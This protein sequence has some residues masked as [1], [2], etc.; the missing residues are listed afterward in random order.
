MS[1]VTVN[2]F[3]VQLIGFIALGVAILV[4]QFNTRKQILIVLSLASLL[5]SVQFFLLGA[6]SGAVLNLIN[7]ARNYA[8]HK[9][10]YRT[11]SAVVL[12]GFVA[13]FGAA[14]ALTWQGSLS[15]LPAIGM[16]S[17]AFANWQP[18]AKHI[19]LLS[20]ISPPAWFIYAAAVHSYAGMVAE[21]LILNSILVG[22]YRYD[23]GDKKIGTL[24]GRII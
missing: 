12:W 8:F 21:V 23:R 5:F 13:I 6:Y 2:P 1:S 3:V 11:W 19:R 9:Y 24:P 18:E 16:I 20:L 7:I 10:R 15:L 14:T 4:Y 22:M 17:G